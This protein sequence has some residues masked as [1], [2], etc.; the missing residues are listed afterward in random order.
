MRVAYYTLILSAV[1]LT[2]WSFGWE[3]EIECQPEDRQLFQRYTEQIEPFAG[4]SIETLL[5]Q[6]ALFF[7]DT[8]YVEH[9]LEVGDDEEKRGYERLIVNLREFDCVTYIE[10][11][12]ALT[13]TVRSGS[14]R[15]DDFA[16]QLQQIRYRDGAIEG[17]ASRLHYVSDWVYNQQQGGVVENISERLG[18][19][20]EEKKIDFMSTHRE[21]YKQLNC[22]DSL[23]L[24]IQRVEES[25]N[26]RGGFFYLPKENISSAAS[27]IPHMSML[28]FTTKIKGLDTTHTGFAFRENGRLTFIHASSA[29][30]KVVIDR[31]SLHDYC[32][33]Q[34]SCTGVIVATI[35]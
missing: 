16:R 22:N 7:V 13:N 1:G 8:P 28:G 21:A 10:T 15:F 11:V 33:R 12:I 34:S 4:A 6:T 29:Q 18:G 19:T 17:Y 32:E 9:T 20:C 14:S 2:F 24:E 25:I 27:R 26:N 5:E 3:T 30:G 35:L 23:W 31:R